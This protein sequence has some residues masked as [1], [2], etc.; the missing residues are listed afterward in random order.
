[1]RH[2]RTYHNLKYRYS[3]ELKVLIIKKKKNVE[4]GILINSRYLDF[5][6]QFF[7]LICCFYFSISIV[8]YYS[9]DVFYSSRIFQLRS[10]VTLLFLF[11]SLCRVFFSIQVIYYIV[12]KYGYKRLKKLY[13]LLNKHTVSTNIHINRYIF[14]I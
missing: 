1:M 7:S 3:L 6:Y 5:E 14:L 2:N 12:T 10:H 11:P 8:F 4:R 9:F 13:L